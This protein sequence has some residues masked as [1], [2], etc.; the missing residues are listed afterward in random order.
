MVL[1]DVQMP[2]MD[3]LEAT[4]RIRSMEGAKGSMPVIALTA[5]V[6]VEQIREFTGA[7]MS[8]HLG[9]PVRRDELL[10]TVDRW[11]KSER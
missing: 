6:F 2:E 10:A 1:M 9:K 5:N 11:L 4:R 8:A 7:G 3:G